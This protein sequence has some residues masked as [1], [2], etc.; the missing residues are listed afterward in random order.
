[1][2]ADASFK[3]FT[4]PMA[5]GMSFTRRGT[6]WTLTLET[7]DGGKYPPFEDYHQQRVAASELHRFIH[8]GVDQQWRQTSDE[9]GRPELVAEDSGFRLRLAPALDE[10]FDAD[11][12]VAAFREAF[13]PSGAEPS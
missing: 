10:P 2:S 7:V 12:L 4:H 9:A 3:V 6:R 1:M 8:M 5:E 13:D 11:S